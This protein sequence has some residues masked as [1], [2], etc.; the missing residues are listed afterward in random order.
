MAVLRWS[1]QIASAAEADAP[2]GMNGQ[3][4]VSVSRSNN[5]VTFS[6]FYVRHQAASSGAYWDW[7]W[8]TDG[9]INGSHRLNNTQ[10]KGRTGGS[11]IGNVWYQTG[12]G[13]HAFSVGTGSGSVTVS[14]NWKS[15]YYGDVSGQQGVAV[16][17]P[18]AGAPAGT[19]GA[20]SGITTTSIQIRNDV[21]SWGAYCTAGSVR[22]Y[23]ADNSGF[24]GQTYIGTT[25]NALVTHTGLTPNDEYWFRGWQNNGAGLS[26]YQGSTR[27]AVTLPNAPVASAAVPLATTA[28]VPTTIDTGGGKYTITKQHRT[29]VAADSWGSWTTYAGSDIALTGL[30]PVTNYE[31]ELRSTTTAG[32]TTGAV[33]SFTTLPAGKLVYSDGEV[34]NAIPR[35]V[36]TADPTVMVNI[37]IIEPL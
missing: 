35:V 27:I 15:N 28:T 12:S 31:V 3:I 2:Y 25:D 10:S 8:Q 9:Y 32:T 16:S 33:T 37:N 22:S 21:T 20:P 4:Y 34:V 17:Y 5:T 24:S 23:R 30:V 7:E 19:T 26:A 29:R 14:A 18:A 1:G 6:S 36:K 13:S 11:N